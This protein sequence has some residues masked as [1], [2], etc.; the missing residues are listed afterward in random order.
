MTLAFSNTVV[1]KVSDFEHAVAQIPD[2][3]LLDASGLVLR[4]DAKLWLEMISDDQEFEGKLQVQ[5]AAVR[6]R[7]PNIDVYVIPDGHSSAEARPAYVARQGPRLL[8]DGSKAEALFRPVEQAKLLE[9]REQDLSR[10]IEAARSR[11]VICA[12]SNYHF[13]LP[14][15][16]HASQFLR[17]AEAFVDIETVDQVAYWIALEIQAKIPLLGDNSPH[18]LL[19]DHPSM[20]ILAARVQLLV[21]VP[22]EVVAFPSYPSDVEMRTASFDLLKR[23]A[24]RSATVFVLIGVASTGRL[25]SFIQRWAQEV[26]DVDVKAL[27]LYSVQ[28]VEEVDVLCRLELPDYQHYSTSTVCALCAAQSFPVRIQTSNYMVGHAPANAVAL[29]PKFFD[30]QRRFIECWGRYPNVLRVHY[31][32][33]NESTARHHAFYVDIGTLLDIPAFA[34]N[35]LLNAK[36]FEPRPEVVVIPDHPSAQRV[37]RLVSDALEIPLTI[38]DSALL[39][40]KVGAVDASLYAASCV[41]VL[42]D[43]F[44]TGSRFDV[45]NRFFRENKVERAPRLNRIHYW[46]L[47]ATPSSEKKYKQAKRGMTTTHGWV[48]TLTH[49][50]KFTLP[51]WHE[52]KDCPWCRELTVL[53]SLTQAVGEFEGPLVDRL[54]DLGNT[55]EGVTERAYFLAHSELVLPSLG[56]ESAALGQGASPLQVLFACASAVQQLRQADNDSLNANQFPAPA[57]LAE[58]VFSKNYTERLIWLG[59]LR[60]LKSKELEPALK[61]YLSEVALNERDGQRALVHGE[62]AVAWVTG[63]LAAIDESLACKHFFEEAGISWQALFDYGLVDRDPSN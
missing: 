46:T 45:I 29:L 9:I 57:Y 55:V 60:S 23:F 12:A 21:S 38:L 51:D 7:A 32:D 5:A 50:N 31:N 1:T 27:I 47:L 43:V 2:S 44:I 15:G 4:V 59:M 58:R 20:L 13:E 34:E 17:L 11:C 49:L 56:A 33:P 8:I 25:A 63:K 18:A 26:R 36:A 48:S 39:S 10:C 30:E 61:T 40:R 16:A 22:L 24:T 28:D 52:A 3:L 35:V 53:N 14:S 42:D 37:G 19:V 54:A 62:L 41:L 6:R